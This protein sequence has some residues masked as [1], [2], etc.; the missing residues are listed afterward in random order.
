MDPEGGFFSD[1]RLEA[2]LTPLAAAPARAVVSEVIA[3][4]RDFAGEEPQA[5]DIAA[6]AIRLTAE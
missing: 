5:D 4:V 6:M 2:V 3:S 1:K